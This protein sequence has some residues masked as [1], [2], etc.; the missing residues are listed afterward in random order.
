MRRDSAL[1]F[2]ET[3]GLAAAIAAADAALKAADV[4]LIGREKSKGQGCIT[5]KITGDVSA[6][7]AA[8]SAAKVAAEEVSQ[9][10]STDVIPRPAVGLAQ[11]MVWNEETEC[12]PGEPDE[13]SLPVLRADSPLV[14]V[15]EPVIEKEPSAAPEA[16]TKPETPFEPVIEPVIK[17][18]PAETPIKETEDIA[19]PGEVP[20]EGSAKEKDSKP[21][22]SD[23]KKTSPRSKQTRGKKKK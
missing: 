18:V 15:S 7:Q 1:G 22:V 4:R 19:V 12:T 14:T 16:E 21:A 2:I 20:D 10:L 13:P 23:G 11:V 3:V 9:V 5:V 8:I 17:D 6:V